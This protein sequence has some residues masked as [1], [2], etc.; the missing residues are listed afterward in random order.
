MTDG[1]STVLEEVNV[2]HVAAIERAFGGRRHA[3]RTSRPDSRNEAAAPDERR[4]RR[5]IKPSSIWDRSRRLRVPGKG[6]RLKA[7]IVFSFETFS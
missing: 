2:E 6:S 4:V 5:P 3:E 1:P 7:R